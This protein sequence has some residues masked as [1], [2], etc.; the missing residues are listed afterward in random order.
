[1]SCKPDVEITRK[2]YELYEKG[3][4]CAK[5]AEAFGVTRQT[6]HKRFKRQHLYQRKIE[7]LPF[8]MYQGEKYTRRVNGYYAKTKGK[9]S[10]L[11]R[12]IWESV[13]GKIPDGFDVHHKDS[14]KTYNVI[15]NFELY[16]KSEHASNFNTGHN[17]HTKRGK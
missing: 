7:A 1:M 6:V 4:S 11:H 15:E 3:F 8:V 14:D 16:S 5:V 10:Y 9:R 2:M 17:Q 12:D 13:N